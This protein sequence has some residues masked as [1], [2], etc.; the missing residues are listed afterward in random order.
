MNLYNFWE[1]LR[2]LNQ[3]I[4]CE[5]KSV[6]LRPCVTVLNVNGSGGCRFT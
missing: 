4:T 3:S 5:M 2:S 1:L 6:H